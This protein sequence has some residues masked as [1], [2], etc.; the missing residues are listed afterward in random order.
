MASAG[1]HSWRG[2]SR[3]RTPC[4][5]DSG[6]RRRADEVAQLRHA[7]ARG[8]GDPEEGLLVHILKEHCHHHQGQIHSQ[9]FDVEEGV[10]RDLLA[11]LAPSTA[12][13]EAVTHRIESIFGDPAIADGRHLQWFLM[14]RR[15]AV[16]LEGNFSR[17]L[18]APRDDSR[19]CGGWTPCRRTPART[20]P[21]ATWHGRGETGINR[22]SAVDQPATSRW[23]ASLGSR[24]ASDRSAAGG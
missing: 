7:D 11:E 22:R 14:D 2:G 15:Q 13:G 6:S 17:G 19:S 18:L 12:G 10:P 1:G 4:P 20:R 8:A 23:K 9:A 24:S 16:D 5:D 3:G 21:A